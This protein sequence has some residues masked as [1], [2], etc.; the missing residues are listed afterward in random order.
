MKKIVLVLLLFFVACSNSEDARE[1]HITTISSLQ[2]QE[3]IALGDVLILDVRTAAEFAEGHIYSAIL[4]PYDVV[5]TYSPEILTD[6]TQTILVY[7]RAGR[8]SLIA[9]E[10]LQELGFAV[11][12]NLDGGLNSWCGP[13]EMLR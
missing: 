3:L 12:Y 6:K 1:P 2:A 13:L 8:R 7:C 11:I 10:K 9:A 5:G 4:L